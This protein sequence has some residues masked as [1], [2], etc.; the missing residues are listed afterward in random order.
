MNNN[1]AEHL[2]EKIKTENISP[3]PRWHF[4]LKNYVVWV[5]GALA[6]IFGSAAIS[7]IIYLLKYNNWEMGLRL[8]GGFLSFFL[9]TLPY[10][11]LIFLGLF[12]FV[13]SYNIKH[14]PKG[15]RYP[16]SFIIIFAILISII[17]GELFFLVGLGR[18]IDD[19]LGQKAPSYAR[20]FN[21]QLGFWLNPEAGRLAG[22]A[23]LNNGDLSIIDPSGKVWEV[24]IP[25]EISNDLELFNGQPLHLIGEATAETTFEAKLIKIPQAGR[26]FMSQP[27]H[28]FPG[29]S[30]EMELKL[31]WKK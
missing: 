20:M 19:I 22:L 23:S 13:L 10:L 24:I 16:F 14:S 3:K 12:I 11:W 5:F 15:Y 4:L 17:L 28:G 21:P 2:L 31:P 1:F 7:V 9:M 26:A 6:L 30:K 27:R 18:K 29:G 8:D 25:A